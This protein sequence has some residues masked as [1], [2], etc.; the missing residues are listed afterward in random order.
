MAKQKLEQSKRISFLLLLEHTTS[1][2]QLK[3]INEDWVTSILNHYLSCPSYLDKKLI[4]FYMEGFDKVLNKIMNKELFGC[5]KDIYTELIPYNTT[6]QDY[7]Y[8]Y[9]HFPET[10]KSN[11]KIIKFDK[12]RP[13]K[14]RNDFD[15]ILMGFNAQCIYL[16]ENDVMEYKIFDYEI[17]DRLMCYSVKY[18][19]IEKFNKAYGLNGLKSVVVFD[20]ISDKLNGMIVRQVIQDGNVIGFLD[21]SLKLKD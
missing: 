6:K 11:L 5:L 17:K 9:I 16:L 1:I 18:D 3:N 15:K 2:N 13:I 10:T 8:L 12:S 19:F 14:L 20:E 4:P 7:P 21:K